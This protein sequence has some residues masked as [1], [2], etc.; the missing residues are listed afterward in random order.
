MF[1]V[2]TTR[3]LCFRVITDNL[4]R[5]GH[6]YF[7]VVDE[8]FIEDDFNLTGLSSLVEHYNEALNILLNLDDISDFEDEDIMVRL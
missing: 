1:L 2:S 6:E 5:P 3:T 4:H 7:V 8:E